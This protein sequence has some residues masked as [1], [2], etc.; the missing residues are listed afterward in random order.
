VGPWQH[1]LMDLQTIGLF[2]FHNEQTVLEQGG[3]VLVIQCLPEP[4]A[5][6]RDGDIQPARDQ[7]KDLVWVAS[8]F[9]SY[10]VNERAPVAFFRRSGVDTMHD[11]C[12]MHDP[13]GGHWN[14]WPSYTGHYIANFCCT[15]FEDYT[16]SLSIFRVWSGVP[17]EAIGFSIAEQIVAACNTRLMKSLYPTVEKFIEYEEEY[18]AVP[19]P[20]NNPDANY[21]EEEMAMFAISKVLAASGIYQEGIGCLTTGPL[22]YPSMESLL[23]PDAL[24]V[25][26]E[27]LTGSRA[28]AEI[29]VSTIPLEDRGLYVH[30]EK[31]FE[32]W[33]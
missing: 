25:W 29:A 9:H 16:E 27:L 17:L 13:T 22:W 30:E 8:L 2:M 32:P 3:E 24:L 31:G 20:E 14:Y 4:G 21:C 11:L 1:G 5:Y 23:E 12:A 28:G 33:L 26:N 7:E 10:P 6:F 19:D 18:G 15:P